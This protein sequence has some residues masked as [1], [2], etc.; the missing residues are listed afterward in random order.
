MATPFD[1]FLQKIT[2]F[3]LEFFRKFYGL[4]RAEVMKV[5]DPESRGRIQIKCPEVGHSAVIN[6]WVDPSFT[7]AGTERGMFWPPEVGDSVYVSFERG[8][9]ALPKVYFGGWFGDKDL[10]KEFGY[11]DKKPKRRGWITR[12]GHMLVFNEEADKEQVELVWH[13]PGSAAEDPKSAERTGKKASLT[14]NKEGDIT[15]SNKNES[16]IVMNAKD[17]KIVITDKDNS[18]KI[19][20][21]DKAITI[22]GDK[23]VVVKCEH[24]HLGEDGPADHLALAKLT[25]A[26]IKAVRDTLKALVGKFNSHKHSVKGIK[27]AGPPPMHTQTAPVDSGAPDNAPADDPAAV[28]DIKSVVVQSK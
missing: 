2:E 11:A 21:T 26:E 16:T 25:K 27:T 20:M 17:K 23:K 14:F 15:L 1:V 7:S 3:G 5:E 12:S 28:A 13:K 9:P 6:R 4:Y 8:D 18:N 24:I 10:P 19:E 22:T